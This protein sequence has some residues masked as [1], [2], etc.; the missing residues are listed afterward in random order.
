MAVYTYIIMP[1]E[2]LRPFER[3]WTVGTSIRPV[4][5]VR[6][7]EIGVPTLIFVLDIMVAGGTDTIGF[8]AA[9]C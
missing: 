9:V 1:R 7:L 2:F 5:L 3:P 6:C 4:I 8:K